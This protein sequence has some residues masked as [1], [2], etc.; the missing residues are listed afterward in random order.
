MISVRV[1][2]GSGSIVDTRSTYGLV[3]IDSDKRV[4]SP[5]KGFEST[6]YPEEEGE[7]IIPVTVDAPFD[8]KAKFFIQA[9]SLA[10]ANDKIHAFNEAFAPRNAE[11][12]TRTVSQVTFFNDYKR[13]KIVGYPKPIEDATEFWRDP[14][15]QVNDV[16]IVEWEIRV[17]KPSLCEYKKPFTEDT[18]SS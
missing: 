8:Y 9:T 13:H 1:K 10:S 16:V 11:T 3:Y 17:T 14:K 4:G 5:V 6:A 18:P 12:G 15:N 2:I 7:H